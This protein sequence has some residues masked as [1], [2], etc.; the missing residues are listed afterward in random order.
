MNNKYKPNICITMI[1]SIYYF[2]VNKRLVYK[3][4]ELLKCRISYFILTL[5]LLVLVNNED[6][7]ILYT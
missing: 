1:L 2:C 3:Q 5:K 6:K 7:P 4:A